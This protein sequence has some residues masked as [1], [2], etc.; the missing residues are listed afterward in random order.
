LNDQVFRQVLYGI[1]CRNYEQAAEQVPGAIGLS[2]STVSRKFVE[3]SARK[4]RE[5][6]LGRHTM[7]RPFVPKNQG[8]S[9]QPH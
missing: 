1:S 8:V 7:W 2:S 6:Q 5:L 3:A 4:L 9:V